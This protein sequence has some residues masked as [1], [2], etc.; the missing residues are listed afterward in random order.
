MGD[1]VP[2]CYRV[3][4]NM[5][6]KR[7]P[8]FLYFQRWEEEWPWFCSLRIAARTFGVTERHDAHRIADYLNANYPNEPPARV[9]R[10]VRKYP[11]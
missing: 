11:F 8:S 2:L 1:A 5:G 9:V 7:A 3:R 4:R 6:T 10:V